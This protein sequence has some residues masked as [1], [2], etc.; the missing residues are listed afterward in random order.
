VAVCKSFDGTHIR[1]FVLR[2]YF[3]QKFLPSG[4][5][6]VVL[7]GYFGGFCLLRDKKKNDRVD[8]FER[9]LC[10]HDSCQRFFVCCFGSSAWAKT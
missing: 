6:I 10:R 7:V 9:F 4:N 1:F 8:F 2:A 3:K 5:H